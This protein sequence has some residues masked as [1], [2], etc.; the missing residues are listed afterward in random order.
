MVIPQ[1][2]LDS[3]WNTKYHRSEQSI[4][5]N[6][7]VPNILWLTPFVVFHLLLLLSSE[8]EKN[9]ESWKFSIRIF[10]KILCMPFW[11]LFFCGFRKW[12]RNISLRQL[13]YVILTW[14]GYVLFKFF[15]C[16]EELR[17][18]LSVVVAAVN[19]SWIRHAWDTKLTT[20]SV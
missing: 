17:Y 10:S 6:F 20:W 7:S 8:L 13:K 12:Y 15:L 18:K 3:C 14:T 1:S 2:M 4:Q 9:T 11:K 5:H 19:A 16:S